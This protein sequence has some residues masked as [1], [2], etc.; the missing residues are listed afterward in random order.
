MCYLFNLLLASCLIA[1]SGLAQTKKPSPKPKKPAS[2]L[3]LSILS[4]K[5]VA[6]IWLQ[7]VKKG[8]INQSVAAANR[9]LKERSPQPAPE[10]YRT[11]FEKAKT[12]SKFLDM[13]FNQYDYQSWYHAYFFHSMARRIISGKKSDDAKVRAIYQATDRRISSQ[14]DPGDTSVLWPYRIWLFRQGLCDR[15]AWVV[16]ELAYQA[17]FEYGIVYF[18]KP[19]DLNVSPH[20]ICEVR[21]ANRQAWTLDPMMNV[22]L[23]E[24][25][26]PRLA[27]R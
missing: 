6:R 1:F 23:P 25:G 22:Y 4:E 27:S 16:G 2:V 15:Q 21:N 14:S 7:A 12:T 13:G 17:G 10:I 8:Q 20:T 24:T 3:D 9:L 5:E 26:I 11:L 18:R 19:E